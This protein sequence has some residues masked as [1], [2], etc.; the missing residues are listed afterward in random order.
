MRNPIKD[1]LKANPGFGPQI[2][3]H[4]NIGSTEK[5]SDKKLKEAVTAFCNKE[6]VKGLPKTTHYIFILDGSGSMSFGKEITVEGYNDQK[7]T[8]LENL[9]VTGK[10]TVTFIDFNT[11]VRIRATA[12]SPSAAPELTVSNYETEGGTA[13]HD[14]IGVAIEKA[15]SLENVHGEDTG[16][17][18]SILTDG[19][20]NSSKHV[21]GGA[22]GECVKQLEDTGK[23]TFALM[24]PKA[25]LETMAQVL[26][27]K[28]GNI[29]GFDPSSLA[30]KCL[31]M[32]KMRGATVAYSSARAA[33]LTASASLY[34]EPSIAPIDDLT[35]K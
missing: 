32:Q 6:K 2:V 4:L 27:V 16:I 14:A 28:S 20:E 12:V 31:S 5:S 26:N 18:V 17:L 11:T 15:L 30:D 24:G 35:K 10:T 9:G 23:F 29:S 8:I 13:L 34:V 19:E 33:S 21:S 3:P 25:Q 1:F 22:L 7:K